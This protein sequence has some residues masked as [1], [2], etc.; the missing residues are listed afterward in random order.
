[1]EGPVEHGRLFDGP[2]VDRLPSHADFFVRGEEDG[3]SERSARLKAWT[4]SEAVA[5]IDRSQHDDRQPPAPPPAQELHV[6]IGGKGGGPV[7]GP[8]RMTS[9]ITMGISPAM[10]KEMFSL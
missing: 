4:V 1:M 3:T 2:H 9:T 7:E 8:W 6:P 5:H 10:A